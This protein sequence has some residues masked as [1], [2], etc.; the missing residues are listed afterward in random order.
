MY[1]AIAIAAFI[2]EFIYML[3]AFVSSSQ[4]VGFYSRF[5]V[6]V[7]RDFLFPLGNAS[8]G[9]DLGYQAQTPGRAKYAFEMVLR[10]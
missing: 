8:S 10:G 7:S 2:C 4:I 9:V 3:L 1:V 6:W 5:F